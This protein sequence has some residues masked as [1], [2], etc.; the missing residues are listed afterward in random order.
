M[1]DR[2]NFYWSLVTS[3]VAVIVASLILFLLSSCKYVT[4]VY[5][6]QPKQEAI[7]EPYQLVR[8]TLELNND[9][10]LLDNDW[11]WEDWAWGELTIDGTDTSEIGEEYVIL[12][13]DCKHEF[14]S[15][16][17]MLCIGGWD[18]NTCTCEDCGYEWKCN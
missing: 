3:L 18:C 1:K 12:S 16:T 14:F 8:P 6:Q 2:F 5:Y 4:V 10:L 15:Q 7:E 17:L 9:S 11:T 13:S